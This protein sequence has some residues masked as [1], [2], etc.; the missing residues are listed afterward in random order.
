MYDERPTTNTAVTKI[1]DVNKNEKFQLEKER[2]GKKKQ[3]KSILADFACKFA[4]K[5]AN[6]QTKCLQNNWC[7]HFILSLFEMWI[8]K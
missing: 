8:E 6:L 4:S 2:K 3:P 5:D 1:Q 7:F